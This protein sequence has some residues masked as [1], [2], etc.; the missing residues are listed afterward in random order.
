MQDHKLLCVFEGP[1]EEKDCSFHSTTDG[2]AGTAPVGA[3]AVQDALVKYKNAQTE[4]NAPV[5]PAAGCPLGSRLRCPLIGLAVLLLA[6]LVAYFY[7]HKLQSM[8]K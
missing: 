3:E 1:G 8:L 6:L 5:E 2:S 4:L 7:G